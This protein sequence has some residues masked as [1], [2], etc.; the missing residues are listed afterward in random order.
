[1]VIRIGFNILFIKVTLAS[2]YIC[3]FLHSTVSQSTEKNSIIFPGKSVAFMVI[4]VT[5]MTNTW[6]PSR[7]R[8]LNEEVIKRLACRHEASKLLLNDNSLS[9][10]L[11]QGDIFK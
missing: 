10:L 6:P 1:M 8:F 4:A 2:K 11:T 3:N 9:S 7:E 5:E